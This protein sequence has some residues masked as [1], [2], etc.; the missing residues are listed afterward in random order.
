M[1]CFSDQ[2]LSCLNMLAIEHGDAVR[3]V[4]RDEYVEHGKEEPPE[5]DQR[6][7]FAG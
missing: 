5:T 2:V 6:D 3:E 1:D 7:I 4:S